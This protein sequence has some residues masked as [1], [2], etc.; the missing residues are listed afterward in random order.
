VLFDSQ[1]TIMTNTLSENNE[2]RAT[3]LVFD[4]PLPPSSLDKK[5]V[6]VK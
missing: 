3:M 6:E 2:E 5:F 1:E 4:Q